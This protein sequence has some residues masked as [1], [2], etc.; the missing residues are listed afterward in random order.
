MFCPKQNLWC[1]VKPFD[2]SRRSGLLITLLSSSASLAM[3]SACAES[4]NVDNIDAY[5]TINVEDY[6]NTLP[7]FVADFDSSTNIGGDGSARLNLRGLGAERTLVL[8]DGRRFASFAGKE[9]FD[10]NNIP[11]ALVERV[12]IL[13]GEGATRYGAG[14]IGGVVNFV[15]RDEFEGFD[16][17]ASHELSVAG[18]DANSTNMSLALGGR[19]ADGRGKASIFA[20]YVNRNE[21]LNG[22]R[23]F[24]QTTLVDAGASGTALIESGSANIPGA[25]LRNVSGNNFGLTNLAAGGMGPSTN[26]NF[27]ANFFIEDLD[28]AC[29]ASNVNACSGV[30]IGSDGQTILGYRD[31]NSFNY[32]QQA[33]LR[34]PMERYNI[35]GFAS[36]EVIDRIEAYLQGVFSN[37]TTATQL[38]PLG[39]DL[40]LTVNLDNPFLTSNS[41]LLNLVAGSGA[42]IGGGEAL[43]RIGK[44]YEEIGLRRST[45]DRTAFQLVG[46]LRGDLNDVWSFDTYISFSRSTN[47]E[48]LSGNVSSAAV[49]AALLCD[50]GPTAIA[51]GC[52]A[53]ALNLFGGP[54][55]I[56]P[57]AAEFVSRTAANTTEVEQFQWNGALSGEFK[58]V[59]MPWTEK[60]V[61]LTIGAEYRE[62]Y[63]RIVPDSALGPDVLGFEARRRL[64][65]RY[66]VYEAFGEVSIP[67]VSDVPLV[68]DFSINGAYRYSDYSISNVGGVHSFAVGGDWSPIPD[69]RLSAQFQR[70]VR[71]PNISELFAPATNSFPAVQ[72]PCFSGGFAPPAPLTISTCIATGVPTALVGTVDLPS[73]KHVFRG[74]NPNLSEEIADTLTIGMSWRPAHIENLLLGVSYYNIDIEDAI[75]FVPLQPLLNE[76]HLLGG[77]AAC[78]IIAGARDPA[79]GLIGVGSFIPTIGAIN[80][81]VR[82]SRGVDFDVR[83][84]FEMAGGT[85]NAS[86]I[87]TY[88]LQSSHQNSPLGVINDCAGRF[89]IDC[90]NPQ[91]DYKH[92]AQIFYDRGRLSLSLRWR[93]IGGVE[94]ESLLAPFVGDLSDSIGAANYVDVETRYALHDNLDVVLGVRNLSG[95]DAPIVGSPVRDQA[96]TWPATYETL[97]R[98]VFFGASLQF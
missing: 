51:S 80:I 65:G 90:G 37:T 24:S 43:L 30:H 11:A 35:A 33:F 27:P 75:T 83:Y 55:S 8:L 85:V 70:A 67:I 72:D 20:T 28:P 54:G 98:Q 47:S 49:Q 26:V 56:S 44:R 73:Q 57:A 38:A 25:R 88:S 87:G 15:L 69:L 9:I 78:E 14:A 96:N 32:A 86:Y 34:L 58:D 4:F 18:W 3:T 76:C 12:E 59:R 68:D 7:Q 40:L 60:G 64:T 42:N 6:L 22:E 94:I 89:G 81:G 77:D 29:G 63:A 41:E 48:I 92:A 82:Q 97:G 95:E 13:T 93:F 17:S 84:G 16:F 23:A 62:N 79:T 36:Y 52:T 39:A 71:A 50:G 66:D 19:F 74:G 2:L 10:V 91:P 45:N 1:V 5:N 46:G 31:A 21:L 53:P 61:A